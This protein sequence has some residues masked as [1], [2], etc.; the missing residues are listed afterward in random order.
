M[1]ECNGDVAALLTKSA[2]SISHHLEVPKQGTYWYPLLEYWQQECWT[3]T[4]WTIRFRS[5]SLNLWSLPATHHPCICEEI[6]DAF[7][8]YTSCCKQSQQIW[9]GFKTLYM[10]CQHI[11]QMEKI[12]FHRTLHKGHWIKIWTW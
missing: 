2:P 11:A 7:V 4:F 6:V 5:S 9:A 8:Y 12:F 10:M 3:Q 1:I